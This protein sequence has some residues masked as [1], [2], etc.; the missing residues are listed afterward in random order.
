MERNLKQEGFQGYSYS[1]QHWVLSASAV[2]VAK[3]NCAA[4]R[5]NQSVAAVHLFAARHLKLITVWKTVAAADQCTIGNTFQLKSAGMAVN[6]SMCIGEEPLCHKGKRKTPGILVFDK[7]KMIRTL[8]SES[9]DICQQSWWKQN[10]TFWH[11]S[12]SHHAVLPTVC[13]KTAAGVN[14]CSIFATE[15]LGK[16]WSWFMYN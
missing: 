5:R 6:S 15:T 7:M 11:Y 13:L 4:N 12:H 8:N 14:E 10:E 3:E 16:K 2:H 1:A 9:F